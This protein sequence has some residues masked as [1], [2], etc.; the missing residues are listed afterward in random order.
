MRLESRRTGLVANQPTYGTATNATNELYYHGLM[1]PARLPEANCP[2]ALDASSNY[3]REDISSDIPDDESHLLVECAR[4]QAR[5]AP[6]LYIN[7][8]HLPKILDKVSNILNSILT[9]LAKINRKPVGIFVPSLY[10]A[11]E[12]EF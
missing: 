7:K 4:S 10:K 12:L 1:R 2:L 6:T 8:A 3:I 5:K 9:D 11:Q